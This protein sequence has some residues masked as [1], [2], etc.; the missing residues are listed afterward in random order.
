MIDPSACV[1]G[2]VVVLVIADVC[3]QTQ[4][5]GSFV[6][7]VERVAAGRVSDMVGHRHHERSFPKAEH[8]DPSNA[9]TFFPLLRGGQTEP[10]M[11]LTDSRIYISRE[12]PPRTSQLST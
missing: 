12:I 3:L 5:I 7:L 4:C 1:Q 11:T 10:R 6:W 2:G 9:A 8:K